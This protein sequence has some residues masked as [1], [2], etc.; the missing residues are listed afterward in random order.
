[1]SVLSDLRS[2]EKV[3]PGSLSRHE[4]LDRCFRS[5]IHTSNYFS[6]YTY[7]GILGSEHSWLQMLQERALVDLVCHHTDCHRL[8]VTY[9]A[10]TSGS[11][12][13]NG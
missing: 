2:L 6:M 8:R 11:Q 9:N 7:R 13:V 4:R 5:R 12:A 1:M 3:L 10:G